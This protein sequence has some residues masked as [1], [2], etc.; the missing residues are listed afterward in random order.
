MQ[1]KNLN[2]EVLKIYSW[3]IVS[4]YVNPSKMEKVTL[5]RKTS[6]LLLNVAGRKT[7]T[8]LM[9]KNKKICGKI[10]LKFSYT[11]NLI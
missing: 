3:G 4:I 10:S 8:K 11:M 9:E 6:N 2:K 5:H 7:D 1:T